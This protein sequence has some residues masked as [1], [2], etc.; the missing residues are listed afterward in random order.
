MEKVLE[1]RPR[2]FLPLTIDN[3]SKGRVRGRTVCRKKGGG[4]ERQRERK[5]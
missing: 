1:L 4:K 2:V 5:F 3:R